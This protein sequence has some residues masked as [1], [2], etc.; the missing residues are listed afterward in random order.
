[1][2]EIGINTLSTESATVARIVA[3]HNAA[4]HIVNQFGPGTP[5]SMADLYVKQFT[6]ILVGIQA[7]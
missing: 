2:A 6:K 1:M 7:A 5:D 4:A 3:A